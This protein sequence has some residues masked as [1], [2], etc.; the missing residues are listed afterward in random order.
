MDLLQL[1]REPSYPSSEYPKHGAAWV[2]SM[3]ELGEL[4]SHYLRKSANFSEVNALLGENAEE[5][6]KTCDELDTA[7]ARLRT[8]IGKAPDTYPAPLDVNLNRLGKQLGLT[9]VDRDLL[10][11]RVICRVN[12][13]L[14]EILN[15][16]REWTESRLYRTLG[17]VLRVPKERIAEALTSGGRLVDTGL[18]RTSIQ[19][20]DGF[21]SRFEVPP[22]FINQMLRPHPDL[23]SL[24]RFAAIRAAPSSLTEEDF[25]Y[26]ARD[27]AFIAA[28]LRG[29]A[30]QRRPGANVLLHGKAGLGKTELAALVAE[31]AGLRL[32][33]VNARGE[34]GEPLDPEQRF[35]AYQLNQALFSRTD[36]TAV[37]FDEVED[38]LPAP[39][40]FGEAKNDGRK[41]WLNRLLETNPVPALWVTNRVGHFD[42]AYLRRFDFV[43]ELKPPPR[44]WRRKLLEAKLAGFKPPADALDRWS[45]EDNLT[46]ALISQGARVLEISKI[47]DSAEACTTFDQLLTGQLGARQLR[48]RSRRHGLPDTYALE[49][50]NASVDVGKLA[51]QL[52]TR[53]HGRLLF[54]GPPGTGK[55]AFAQFLA[56]LLDRPLLVK[57]ASDLL[58][59]YVGETEQNLCAMFEEADR[60]DALLMLD[61]ADSFLQDRRQAMRAWEVTQVNELLV[62]MESFSGLFITATNWVDALDAAAM[63]RFGLIV[64]FEALNERQ[65][66]NLFWHTLG[67][68]EAPDNQ[69]AW[70]I[71]TR[72]RQLTAVTAGDFAA[73]VQRVDILGEPLAPAS[74]LMALTEARRLKPGQRHATI[75]FAA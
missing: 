33:E 25:G 54:H 37:L 75:G 62:Q 40:P 2:A 11:F 50:I 8:V 13:A 53:P 36:K 51:H 71:N 44:S 18:V 59:K 23:D 56:D 57:R 28:Y 69:E 9:R 39:S 64:A 30:T 58:S 17:H 27:F 32:Y 26:L 46:P 67:Q 19:V 74:L 34:Q 61:E 14:F 3:L 47:R 73:A 41:A 45:A 65:R 72:L 5:P 15:L 21:R 16:S 35:R 49:Y 1:F 38:V 48:P 22:G 12:S 68:D 10:A 42:P 29:A 31:A 20:V 55:T 4:R 6:P 66:Q 60:D 63:R 70:T 24:L 7:I 52:R 43:M